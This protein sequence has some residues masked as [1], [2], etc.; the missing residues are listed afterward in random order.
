MEAERKYNFESLRDL[1][2]VFAYMRQNPGIFVTDAHPSLL[3]PLPDGFEMD[4]EPPMEITSP[5]KRIYF[6]TEDFRA[7][8]HNI[9]MR[10]EK[11]SFGVKQIIK[12]GNAAHLDQPT[13]LRPEYPS[14]LSSS[15]INLDAISD[16]KARKAIKKALGDA[17][18]RPILSILSQRARLCYHPRGNP[19]VLVEVAFDQLCGQT[20]DQD[21]VWAGFQMEMEIKEGPSELADINQIMDDQEKDIF[22]ASSRE[23]IREVTS[24]PSPGYAYL[25]SK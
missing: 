19:D 25:K 6:D 22:G 4:L 2:R 13:L 21:Y 9:E 15:G 12:M 5:R 17:P 20:F 23:M 18:I 11:K 7:E 1:R 8:A 10:Q 16:K 24:K 14:K 3:T